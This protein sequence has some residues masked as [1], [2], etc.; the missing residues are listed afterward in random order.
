MAA[1]S[2]IW[3]PSC[4]RLD[5]GDRVGDAGWYQGAGQRAVWLTVDR[6]A[7]FFVDTGQAVNILPVKHGL[8]DRNV[9]CIRNIVGDTAALVGGKAARV[10]NLGQQSC[11]R[12]AVTDLQRGV[13]R[14]HYLTAAVYAV[15]NCREAVEVWV[16]VAVG[17]AL[18]F[19]A[20]TL[21]AVFVLVL[22]GIGVD[23]GR[24]QVRLAGILQVLEQLDVIFNQAHAGS[25]LDQGNA[26]LFGLVELVGEYFVLRQGFV[27]G[28]RLVQVYLAAGRPCGKDLFTNFIKFV[29]G[30][31]FIFDVNGFHLAFTPLLTPFS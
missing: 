6:D 10:G 14:V 27:V 29:V 19:A 5:D 13:Q 11:V 12:G 18:F 22:T 2:W 28:N 9:L 1:T 16:E 15:V 30:P 17:H 7:R 31:F 24:Q 3:L 26:F 4:Q 21:S 8:L 23:G 25:W 20:D